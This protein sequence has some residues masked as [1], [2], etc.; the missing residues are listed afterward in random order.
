MSSVYIVC[1]INLIPVQ[2]KDILRVYRCQQIINKKANNSHVYREVPMELGAKEDLVAFYNKIYAK[3]LKKYAFEMNNHF[4]QVSPL[5]NHNQNNSTSTAQFITPVNNCNSNNT[6][7]SPVTNISS[8]NKQ[9]NNAPLACTQFSPR[10]VFNQQLIFISPGKATTSTS[11]S[12]QLM[13]P[14]HKRNRLN[15]SIN[16]TNQI[17]VSRL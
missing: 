8:L 11:C 15:F 13:Q 6:S 14:L 1:R 12:F 2:F 16:D 5:S 3:K 9:P 10:K 4:K 17:K 7:S